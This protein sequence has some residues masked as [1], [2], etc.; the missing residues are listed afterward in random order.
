MPGN[1]AKKAG[2][3]QAVWDEYSSRA[4]VVLEKGRFGRWLL[5]VIKAAASVVHGFRGEKI[6]LRASALTYIAMLSLVPLLAVIFAI[7]HGLGQES[8]RKGVHEFVFDNLAPGVREQIG[9]YLDE[10]IARASASAMGGLGGVFLLVSAVGLF[11]NIERSLDEIWG[12]TTPRTVLR[13]VV[14]YWCVLTLGP[15]VLCVSVLATNFAQAAVQTSVPSGVLAMTPWATS[16][17]ALFFLYF[18]VPNA[19]VRPQAALVG[20]LVAGTAWEIAKHIYSWG[21]THS[22]KYNAIYGSLGAVPLFLLWVYVSWIV[23]LFGARLA[24]ALQYAIT[25]A[26]AP[27]VFDA[28]CREVLCARVALEA[29]VAFQSGKAPPTPGSIAQALSLDVSFIGEAIEAL[30]EKG[31][32]AEAVDG[33]VVPARALD[34]ISVADIAEAARGTLFDHSADPPSKEAATRALSEL[35]ADSDRKGRDSLRQIALGALAKPI[36]EGG[37]V[38]A[39]EKTANTTR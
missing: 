4:V 30:R 24:Y 33:G 35:F 22:F 26:H 12:V 14:I 28:R 10:F 32:V 3:H 1:A 39:V 31:L 13:R 8:L 38:P 5:S 19:K 7:V 17:F 18:A 16:V 21:A 15:V 6:T 23:V 2:W 27:R 11:H 20:A 29:A 34:Q 25:A 9:G 37:S 36:V